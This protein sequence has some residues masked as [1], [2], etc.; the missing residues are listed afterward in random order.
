MTFVT[1]CSA[2]HSVHYSS[3]SN[4]ELELPHLYWTVTANAHLNFLV[5]HSI[6]GEFIHL[7]GAQASTLF[8]PLVDKPKSVETVVNGGPI[9][10]SKSTIVNKMGCFTDEDVFLLQLFA[11]QI[12]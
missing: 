11:S 12:Y 3:F 6:E 2:I 7:L 8:N 4:T 9:F 10:N 5:S 1:M